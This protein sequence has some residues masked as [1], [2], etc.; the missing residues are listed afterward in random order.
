MD[1]NCDFDGSSSSASMRDYWRL[2]D[3]I[4]YYKDI[5]N[6]CCAIDLSTSSAACT[7]WIIL[8]MSQTNQTPGGTRLGRQDGILMTSSRPQPADESL[9]IHVCR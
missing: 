1:G 5:A 8:H 3:D 4:L 7:W 2:V 9:A 6:Q